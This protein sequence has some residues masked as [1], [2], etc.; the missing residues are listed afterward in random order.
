[1]MNKKLRITNIKILVDKYRSIIDK[2]GW[3][4]NLRYKKYDAINNVNIE[5]K[6]QED[7]T[8]AQ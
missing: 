1:M 2:D 4:Y 7:I 8:Q 3:N 5:E 6:Q